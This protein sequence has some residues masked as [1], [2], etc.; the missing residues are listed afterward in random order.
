MLLSGFFSDWG[1]FVMTPENRL[2]AETEKKGNGDPF[3]P[4]WGARRNQGKE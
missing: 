2:L 4:C 3:I 1:I